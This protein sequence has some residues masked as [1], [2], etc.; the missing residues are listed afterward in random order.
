MHDDLIDG[1]D[2][3]VL[4]GI[5]DP[6]RVAIMG[7]SYGGYATLWGMT[8]T[9][10]TF[11]CGVDIAGPS[12]MITLFESFPPHGQADIEV[13]ATRM[14]DARTEEGREL[15]AERSPLTYVDQIEKPLLIGQGANDPRVKQAEPDQIVHA[16]QDANIPVTYLLYTD[17][18]HG[19][20]RPENR[21]SFFAVAEAFLAEHLGG[22]YEPI[23]DDFEGRASRFLSALKRCRVLQ[24]LFRS[25]YRRDCCQA[26][27]GASAS[28]LIWRLFSGQTESVCR[29]RI[30]IPYTTS[31][32]RVG[33]LLGGTGI[34]GG[35]FL[36]P[37]CLVV[38]FHGVC[39]SVVKSYI[40]SQNV[41]IN[42]KV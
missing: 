35:R 4:E 15:L 42:R 6:D 10:D 36:T 40:I 26:N 41:S 12:N 9:P 37:A 34:V 8:N 23:G 13:F 7:I 1:V 27:P 21:L 31:S 2:W 39:N 33:L 5:A 3:S 25:S 29:M 30:P 32:M 11:A 16:M 28:G 17:E 22:R 14:G 19:F 18:G 38:T 20:A 24:R